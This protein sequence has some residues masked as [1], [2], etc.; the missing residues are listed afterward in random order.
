[1]PVMQVLIGAE[2]ATGPLRPEELVDA[3]PWP[4][5]PV[6]LRAMMVM[7]LDGAVMGPDGHS[8]SIS[9]VH[10][11]VLLGAVRRFADVVLIGAG[12]FRAERYRP[13][14]ARPEDA[15]RRAEEGLAPAPTLAIVS[16]SLDLPW[17]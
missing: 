3:Y 9:S 8:R 15:A 17:D 7:T 4:D 13:M 10:D 16:G 6:W 12:T 11:R 1:M 5:E 14:V 2:R